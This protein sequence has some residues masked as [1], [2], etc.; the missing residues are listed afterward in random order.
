MPVLAAIGEGL[1]GLEREGEAERLTLAAGG[2]AA[3]ILVMAARLCAATRL[4]G[5]VGSDPLGAWLLS[6][7]D[8]E[9]VDVSHVRVDP[10]ATTGLYL[11]APGGGGHRFVYW[12]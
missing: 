6:F 11:N 9:G 12:R 7:W 2:D 5:R 1:V 10:D 4:L 8:G 3:N